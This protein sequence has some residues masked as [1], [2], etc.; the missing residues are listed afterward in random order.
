MQAPDLQAVVGI[1]QSAY[2]FP[3]TVGIF[4]DCLRT[5]Y[6][7]RVCEDESG[8]VGYGIMS[9]TA[10]ECHILNI[11]V[12]KES[13][14]LGFGTRLLEHLLDVACQ[15]RGRVAFLEVR[16]SNIRAYSLYT[17]LGF[18]EIGERRNYYP[19]ARGK[20]EHAVVLAKMLE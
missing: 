7:C 16:K 19:A 3:W 10:G 6:V 14:R 4:R 17:G 11:C 18:N 8:V 15:N 1:E 13:Q 2:K 12:H 9:I 20:R 5:G